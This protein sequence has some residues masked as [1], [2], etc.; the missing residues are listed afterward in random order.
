[1][2]KNTK[3]P[4]VPVEDETGPVTANET[5]QEAETDQTPK[6][7]EVPAGHIEITLTVYGPL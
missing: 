5:E 4:I 3:S 7:I 1:M 6:T 2:A